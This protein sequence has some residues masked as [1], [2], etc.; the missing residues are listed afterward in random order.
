MTTLGGT[1]FLRKV[2][3]QP[4]C[5]CAPRRSLIR[6]PADAFGDDISD[7]KVR[8]NRAPIHDIMQL[9]SLGPGVSC[10]VDRLSA[11]GVVPVNGT[12]GIGCQS[13]YHDARVR[14]TISCIACD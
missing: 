12:A 2:L 1:L 11:L 7:Q 8:I 5:G 3:F 9:R 4:Q 14:R 13:E 6:A 10:V